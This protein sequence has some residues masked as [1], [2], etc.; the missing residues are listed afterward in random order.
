MNFPQLSNVNSTIRKTVNDR[1]GNTLKMSQLKPWIR[2]MTASNN[3]LVVESLPESVSFETRYG[4]SQKGGMV[5]INWAGEP[6]YEEGSGRG[7]RPSPIIDGLSVGN[8]TQGLSR[9]I[10]CTV[11]CFTLGQAELIMQYFNEPG[12]TV[13]VEYGWNISK[14]V[15]QK[16][17][18]T[19]CDMVKYNS[20][21]TLK[22]KRTASEG[23]YD[24]FLGYI[25]GGGMKYGDGESFEVSIELTTLGEIPA[26]LQQHKG[27]SSAGNGG[28]G[29]KET[30]LKFQTWEIN[31]AVE[32]EEVGK[33]LFMQM[34]NEL[35]GQK[36]ISQV[37]ELINKNEYLKFSPSSKIDL[38][39]FADSG[40]FINMDKEIREMLTDDLSDTNLRLEQTEENKGKSAKV[41]EGVPL[42]SQ[43]RFIRMGLALEILNTVQYP[44]EAVASS[45][46]GTP[47]MNFKILHDYTICRAHKHMFSTDP[48]K[49][50]IPNKNMPEFGLKDALTATDKLDKF[51]DLPNLSTKIV[52]IHP[53]TTSDK[54]Y[55]PKEIDLASTG[56]PNTQA[57]TWDSD[58]I[59][60][61]EDAYKYGLLAD[62]FINFDFFVSCMSKNGFVVKDILLDMLNGMSSAVNFYWDFQLSESGG[63]DGYINL[64]IVDHS[65]CGK[66][67]GTDKITT[68]QSRGLD[69]PFLDCGLDFDIPGA[70]KNQI[71]AQRCS[72]SKSEEESFVPDGREIPL[73]TL[74]A[75]ANDPVLDVLNSMKAD[76]AESQQENE[77]NP[78]EKTEKEK[79]AEVRKANYEL[80]MGKA[81]VYPK[82][83]DRN[84]NTDAEKN[85][86]DFFSDSNQNSLEGLLFVG[87]W[88]DTG[89]LKTIQLIDEGKSGTLQKGGEGQT[90]NSVLLPIKFSFTIPGVSG[91]L[92]GNIFKISDLPAKY[93]D[94][95]FQVTEVEHSIDDG[96]WSTTVK[97]QIRNQT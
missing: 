41:P 78:P 15:D 42:I 58:Y 86:Y 61:V 50:F 64:N 31:K 92:I 8:G 46:G 13:L 59:P 39:P 20:L 19:V 71:V 70:M 83:Q 63:K 10:S 95:V 22:E 85:W 79:E 82:V 55:F 69:S 16:C 65:F 24:A 76:I 37:K 43:E 33:A 17:P 12:Y 66:K 7:Y 57:Y 74:F 93:R 23:T 87:T 11:K 90:S 4:N 72:P 51:I 26:Y 54:R 27:V 1:I 28:D 40:N 6:V 97:A 68:W 94:R 36:Q 73:D 29:A 14:S 81:G 45:C 84:G 2:L 62:L 35:P 5:G 30:S 32:D 60:Y 9:K 34:F 77:E 25:T 67:A 53:E 18:M 96:G 3:G 47:T 48:T 38:G 56:L 91:L 52:D 80:F 49:L 44:F 75:K 89:L 88:K 21:G